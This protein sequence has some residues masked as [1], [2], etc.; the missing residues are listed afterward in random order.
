MCL[1]A[2]AIDAHPRFPLVL[3]ANRGFRHFG[4]IGV[5]SPAARHFT[6][7]DAHF[8][9]ALANVLGAATERARHDERV[10]DSEARFREPRPPR[11]WNP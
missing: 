3:A 10:R 5:H 4:V 7:D 11:P 1:A 8:L 9:Q 2:L 6:S